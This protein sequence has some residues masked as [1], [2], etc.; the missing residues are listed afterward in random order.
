M[1]K[2]PRIISTIIIVVERIAIIVAEVGIVEAMV[3]VMVAM[4]MAMVMLFMMPS[5]LMHPVNQSRSR[6]GYRLVCGHQ[7]VTRERICGGGLRKENQT[8]C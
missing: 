4:A 2:A 6:I 8:K 1:P 3:A 7:L 5:P